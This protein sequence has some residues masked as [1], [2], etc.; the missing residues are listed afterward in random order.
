MEFLFNGLLS[1]SSL[2][3]FEQYLNCLLHQGDIGD[4][5]DPIVEASCARGF[6]IDF[7]SL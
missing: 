1:N 2:F 5:N 6:R 4:G 7:D 3:Q